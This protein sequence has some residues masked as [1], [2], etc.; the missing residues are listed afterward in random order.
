L[1][2]LTK[3]AREHE[4][5]ALLQANL[6]KDNK[7]LLAEKEAAANAAAAAT[8]EHKA[9]REQNEAWKHELSSRIAVKRCVRA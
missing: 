7:K 4:G 5:C 3:V 6:L 8:R 2:A 1:E 9:V